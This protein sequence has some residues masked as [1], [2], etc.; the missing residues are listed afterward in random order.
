[1]RRDNFVSHSSM[2]WFRK[3]FLSAFLGALFAGASVP[4]HSATLGTDDR[5]YVSTAPGSIYS[6][7]GK[8]IRQSLISSTETTGTLVDECHVLTA[9]HIFSGKRNPVGRHLLFVGAFRTPQ[10]T[11]S[12]GTVVA[13]GGVVNYRG[14]AAEMFNQLQ[15]D[16]LLLRLTTCLGKTLGCAD[17]SDMGG[18]YS[19]PVQNAGY[20][21]DRQSYKGLTVDPSCRIVGNYVSLL[22]VMNNCASRRANSGGPIFRIVRDGGQAR[23]QILAIENL[24]YDPMQPSPAVIVWLNGATSASAF[25]PSIKP[26]LTNRADVANGNLVLATKR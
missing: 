19:G 8:V 2:R 26:F 22:A 4:A 23:I 12:W 18:Y 1:M 17:V 10:E 14:T 21:F 5:E 9:E 7:I 16:W 6:P 13:A 11:S 25:L 24:A 3:R 20:P 15:R